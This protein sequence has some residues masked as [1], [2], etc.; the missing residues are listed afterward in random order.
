MP[1]ATFL[2]IF[3][4]LCCYSTNISPGNGVSELRM[5]WA[6]QRKDKQVPSAIMENDEPVAGIS[7]GIAV[8]PRECDNRHYV[9]L[10]W[11]PDADRAD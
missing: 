11:E 4:S 7:K 3:M 8:M 10:F 2:T 1:Y 6:G 9:M 5:E